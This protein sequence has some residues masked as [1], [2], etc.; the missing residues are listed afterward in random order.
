MQIKNSLSFRLIFI[1]CFAQLLVACDSAWLSGHDHSDKASMDI[2]TKNATS[3]QNN[4]P[5]EMSQK[6][7]KQNLLIKFRCQQSPHVG[8]FQQCFVLLEREGKK[9]DDAKVS[10][11]GGMKAHGHGLPT[12]PK[13]T[14]TTIAGQYKIEGLKFSMP[15]DWVVG[16]RVL[17]EKTTDQTVFKFSI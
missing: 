2:S 5:W 15:G 17:L 3:P 13:I 16:F 6:T 12:S 8:G 1:F 14:A 4:T 7:D 11:D 9:V 10:I